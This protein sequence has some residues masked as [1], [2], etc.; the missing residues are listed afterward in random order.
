MA[1]RVIDSGVVKSGSPMVR[2]M[3]SFISASMSK[4]RRMPD[5]GM[6]RTV[7]L[8][9]SAAARR[10]AGWLDIGVSLAVRG[11]AVAASNRVRPTW[12]TVELVLLL[13]AVVAA[14]TVLAQRFGIPYPILDGHRRGSSSAWCQA[15]RRVEL[16][17][18]TVLVL[19]L[20]PI[21]FSAAYFLS[22]RDLRRNARPI[23]LLA[24]GLVIVTTLAVAAVAM[25]MAP[26]LG[27]PVAIALGAIV[28]PPDAIAATSIARRL[29]LPRRLVVIFE[30]ESLVNDATALT[31]YRLAV[32]AA[33]AGIALDFGAAATGFVR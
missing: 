4:K 27:W 14:V 30:G 28:S 17:P 1:A 6:A 3:T 32:V 24:V 15:S 29:N 19:F 33:V 11:R 2:L 31:F 21:L 12:K 22:P 20:P 26:E 23:G 18:E 13:L 9:K 16:D 25:A 5:G 7:P 10:V 8:R